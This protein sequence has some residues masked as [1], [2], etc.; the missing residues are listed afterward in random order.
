MAGRLPPDLSCTVIVIAVLQPRYSCG[1]NPTLPRNTQ[2]VQAFLLDDFKLTA[3][4]APAI[5]S[6]P[7]RCLGLLG[8]ASD[9]HR[10]SR[11][12]VFTMSR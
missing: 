10:R 11:T 9:G 7:K 2:K 8:Y 4:F 5:S 6:L 1:S 3:G 12:S